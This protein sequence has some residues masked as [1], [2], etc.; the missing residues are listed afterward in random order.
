MGRKRI[1]AYCLTELNRLSRANQIFENALAKMMDSAHAPLMKV[2][3]GEQLA[4]NTRIGVAL[5]KVHTALE[6]PLSP[7]ED[8][9]ASGI[10]A[11]ALVSCKLEDPAVRDIALAQAAVRMDHWE[12]AGYTGL[13][14]FL[15]QV[16]QDDAADQID[17]IIELLGMAD[18]HIEALRPSLTEL[19]HDDEAHGHETRS[20]ESR[21]QK[22]MIG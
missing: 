15:R 13:T 9:G 12:L 20:P 2:T 6:H 22:I 10:A 1:Y 11:E 14:A 18:R 21:E 8:A 5:L 3:L 16:M 7:Q 4:V 17:K 19:S